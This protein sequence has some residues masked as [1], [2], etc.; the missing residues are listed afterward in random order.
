MVV[1]LSASFKHEFVTR[2]N[3]DREAY[4]KVGFDFMFDLRVCLGRDATVNIF[5]MDIFQQITMLPYMK[6]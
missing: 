6:V 1:L 5:V 2:V 4:T 3:V